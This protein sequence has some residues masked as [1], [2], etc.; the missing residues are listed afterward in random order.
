MMQTG[1]I[2]KLWFQNEACYRLSTIVHVEGTRD[3]ILLGPAASL[4]VFTHNGLVLSSEE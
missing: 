2:R 3:S 4:G 1:Y